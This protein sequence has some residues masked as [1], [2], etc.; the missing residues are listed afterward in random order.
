[1]YIIWRQVLCSTAKLSG[2]QPLGHKELSS[3]NLCR[4]GRK[5]VEK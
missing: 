5:K 3:Q 1:M 2:V 4:I